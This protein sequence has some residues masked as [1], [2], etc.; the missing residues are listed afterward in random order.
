M[1]WNSCEAKAN[2]YVKFNLYSYR[3]KIHIARS[4]RSTDTQFPI[5]YKM[6]TES[7][8]KIVDKHKNN[9]CALKIV[10]SSM[11]DIVTIE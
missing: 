7:A 5:L 8:G 1:I 11:P 4:R 6:S 10:G 2:A 9:P 3:D